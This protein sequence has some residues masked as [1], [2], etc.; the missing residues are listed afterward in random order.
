MKWPF[1]FSAIFSRKP[2]GPLS[3]P[4]CGREMVMVER[5]TMTGDDMRTYRCQRCKKEHVVNFGTAMWKL[6]SDANK[7]ENDSG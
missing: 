2:A 6:I 3:C 7:S 5:F 1:S 4:R